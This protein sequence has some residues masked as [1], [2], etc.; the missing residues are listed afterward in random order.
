MQLKTTS[1]G[2]KS[3]KHGTWRFFP[4]ES[5]QSLLFHWFKNF[6]YVF[7]KLRLS[8]NFSHRNF[9]IWHFLLH[10]IMHQTICCQFFQRIPCWLDPFRGPTVGMMSFQLAQKNAGVFVRKCTNKKPI[11]THPWLELENLDWVRDLESFTWRAEDKGGFCVCVTHLK[12]TVGG[13]SFSKPSP[14]V[15][16]LNMYQINIIEILD[17]TWWNS[18]EIWLLSIER[19]LWNH[20]CNQNETWIW[21]IQPCIEK[22]P[23]YILV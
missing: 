18:L 8:P 16:F 17:E 22:Q 3:S 4:F 12:F 13:L 14:F 9:F 10:F 7:C 19:K 20:Q 2:K 15:G 5:D 21:K 1:N 23:C 11:T 6:M